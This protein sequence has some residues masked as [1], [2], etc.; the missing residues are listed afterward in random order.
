M[1]QNLVFSGGGINCLCYIGVLKYI[2]QY[3]LKKDVKRVIGSS[4]ASLFLLAFVLNYSYQDI[5]QIIIGLNLDKIKDIT[6]DNI[7]EFFNNYGF[8]TGKKLEQLIKILIKKKVNDEDITFQK[9]YDLIPIEFTITGM[10]LNKKETE[11]FNYKL[12]PD[13]PVYLAIRISCSIPLIYNSVIYKNNMYLDGGLLDNYPINFFE[14]DIE[15]TLGFCVTNEEKPTE[16]E[17]IDSYIYNIITA[18]YLRMQKI[19]LKKYSNKS[20]IIHSNLLFTQFDL[21]IEQKKKCFESGYKSIESYFN[22]KTQDIVTSILYELIDDIE[23][24]LR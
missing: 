4:G 20:I 8:D 14:N 19:N 1:P 11:Y 5:E 2:E 16:I 17:G 3:D 7:F 18:L 21:S 13:M 15:N 9:L 24:T 22:K 10:C 6:T 12:T 23:A